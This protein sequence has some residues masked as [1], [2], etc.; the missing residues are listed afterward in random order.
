MR[1]FTRFVSVAVLLGG[2]SLAEAQDLL[3]ADNGIYDYHRAPRYRE[4]ESHPLRIAAYIVHPVGWLLREGVTRPIS[5]FAGSTR[6]TR[7]FFG[8]REP[9]DFRD[10]VCFRNPDQVPDCATVAPMNMIGGARDDSSEGKAIETERQVYFPDVNFEFD[11]SNLTPLG[12]GRVRQVAQLLSSVPSLK[13]VVEGH[14]DH[15]G[16]DEYNQALGTRRAESV[17]KELGELGVDPARMSSVSYGESRPIFTEDED[18]ARAVNRR[19]QFTVQ[20]SEPAPAGQ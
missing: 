13:V 3:P 4:T 9:F 14:A 6:F 16:T 10:P 15:R 20:G 1:S 5:A 12:K 11:K 18:W 7:S 17:I 2:V 8:F 19:T